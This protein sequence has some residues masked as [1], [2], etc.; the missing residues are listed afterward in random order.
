MTFKIALEFGLIAV[1]SQISPKNLTKFLR[2][3][4]IM[5]G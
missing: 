1:K 4:K 5:V 3:D 2:S